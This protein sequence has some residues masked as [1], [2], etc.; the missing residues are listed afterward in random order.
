MS[1]AS[2]LRI[3]RAINL[4]RGER[5]A[6]VLSTLVAADFLRGGSPTFARA[7]DRKGSMVCT[8]QRAPGEG[9]A[10]FKARAEEEAGKDHGGVSAPRGGAS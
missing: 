5:L 9:W 2:A 7:F 10:A 8:I 6:G 3:Q 1:V 4:R